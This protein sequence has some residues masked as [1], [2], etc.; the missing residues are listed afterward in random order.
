MKSPTFLSSHPCGTAPTICDGP[1]VLAET[2]AITDY[3]V[4]KYAPTPNPL[5]PSP[6][7][8]NFADYIFWRHFAN[9]TLGPSTGRCMMFAFAGIDPSSPMSA[10]VQGRLVKACQMVEERL[11]KSK[12][13]AGDEFTLADLMTVWWFT[14][15]RQFYPYDLT[16]YPNVVAWLKRVGERKAYQQA[17]AK[18]DPGFTPLLGKEKPEMI[19]RG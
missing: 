7:A 14:G 13:L 19:K 3:L 1:V 12:W 6:S 9:G 4:A 17:M 16:A 8:S 5:V 10:G 11:G 15:M 18:G 2:D